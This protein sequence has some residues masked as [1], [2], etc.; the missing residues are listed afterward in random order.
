MKKILYLILFTSC[1]YSN[2]LYC[3]KRKANLAS[4]PTA[5]KK[6]RKNI[7]D[8][9]S[10]IP[11]R[12]S[13]SRIEQYLRCPRCFYL[14]L[15]LGIKCPP[16]FPFNL[17]NA[18][19]ELLKKEFDIYREKGEP[20]PLFI[21]N[22][23]NDVIPFK[24]KNLNTWRDALHHGIEYEVPDTNLKICGG[25]DDVWI[26]SEGQ[27]IIADYKAT[28]KKGKVSLDADWQISYKRQVEIYQWLFRQ[29]GFNVS[30]IAYFVYCNGKKDRDRFDGILEFDISLLSY[31][32][33]DSWIEDKIM[34]IYQCLQ[35][36]KI[37]QDAKNC[38]N[39][40]Y[41][42]QYQDAVF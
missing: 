14:D 7:Y 5:T 15:K 19:D 32:G 42:F 22:G 24:H 16:G 8:P 11:F 12:L 39:C 38:S 26:T 17:N 10:E 40:K 3:G 34:E 21:E 18:V 25:I 27:L 6:S 23:L 29:N 2:D 35:S 36:D 20:H 31:E 13:R 30:D 4:G 37:P 41:I 1:F 9:N 28:S 33:G